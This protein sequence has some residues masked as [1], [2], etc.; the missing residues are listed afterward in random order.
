MGAFSG[1]CIVAMAVG[2]VEPRLGDQ[3]AVVGGLVGLIGGLWLI[4]RRDGQSGG[5]VVVALNILAFIL[6]G[7]LGYVAFSQ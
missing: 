2:Y 1:A 3:A 7:C 6:I 5:S 4:L